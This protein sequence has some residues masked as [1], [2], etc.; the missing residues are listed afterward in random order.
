MAARAVRRRVSTALQPAADSSS[1]SS[2]TGST[3]ADLSRRKLLRELRPVQP[4]AGSA[5]RV[6]AARGE[7]LVFAANDYLGL[8]A[9]AG[10]RA[11]AAAAAAEHG[12][13]PRSSALVCGHTDAHEDL[14]A[15]LARLKACEEAL[16]FPTGF[17]ANMAVLGTLADGPECAIFSDALNH[18][19]I[20]DGARLA[21]RGA[22]ASLH[23]YRHND[24]GHLESLLA[25]SA[26]PRKLI[27][28]DSLFSMD[29]DLAD[30]RGLAALRDRYATWLCLDEAHA[31]LVYGEHGGGVAEAQGVAE[32]VDVHVGTLSKAFGSHGG[33]VGCSAQLKSLLISRGRAGIYST[34]LPLPAVAAA[35]AALDLA[36][37][38]LRSQLWANV[39]A[40]ASAADASTS[41]AA[42]DA[43]VRASPMSPIIPLVV[44]SE[45]AALGAA[46]QL[47]QQGFLVPAIRPPTVPAG[48]ARLR[49]ALSAA[50]TL[51]DVSALTRALARAGVL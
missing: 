50:H 7:L 13:G 15:A 16:L 22:G 12:S 11:A 47:Q 41:A 20:V 23:I 45:E 43:L 6:R 29:G 39:G 28:S 33:F 35:R 51:D 49:V 18:A 10:V 21:A 24:L 42:T 37:P 27:I 31:T 2:W 30:V 48:T 1:W 25:A 36:T 46:E 26:A 34:A 5:C 32:A 44:G 40:F 14:E 38:T 3:T 17:A 4:I 19:S 8:S 9:H